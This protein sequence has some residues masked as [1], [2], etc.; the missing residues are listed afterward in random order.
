MLWP[1]SLVLAE[2]FTS[3]SFK[4]QDPVIVPAGFGSSTN[5]QLYGVLGQP[6]VGTSTANSFEVRSG[7][8][9][10]PLATAPAVVATAG[11]SQV[12]LSWT[13]STGFLGW[14][15]S[16]YTVGQSITS[17]GPYSYNSVGAVLSSTRGSLSNG[18]IYYFVIRA[19]D[20]FGNYIATSSEASAT[21]VASAVPATGTG[22]GG[23]NGPVISYIPPLTTKIPECEQ[24][25]DLNCDSYVDIIDF[26]IMYYWF[27]KSN[28][29]LRVDLKPDG[30]IN[31]F[32]FSVMA[33][34]WHE[35]P[36]IRI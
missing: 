4:S 19:Q 7:F 26:S 24:I 15:V 2:D 8:L 10:F 31:I 9:Y 23:G 5:F 20:F 3:S 34:Y 11:D 35:R 17:G 13:A 36:L 1:G 33:Y 14:T 6:S 16:G 18:T 25:A 12:A 30:A 22:G 21:P 28:P 29:P 27:D 32:D